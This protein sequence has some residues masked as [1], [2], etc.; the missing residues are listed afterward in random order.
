MINSYYFSPFSLERPTYF[1]FSSAWIEHIPFSFWL[2]E[3]L[4]PNIIVEL[5]THKGHSYFSFCQAVKKLKMD[6]RCYA[7]DHW[8]GDEHSGFYGSEVYKIVQNYNDRHYSSFSNLVRSTFNEASAHFLDKSIDLLHIDGQH[9]YDDVKNDFKKWEP[10]L[11]KKSIVLFHDTNVRERNFGVFKFWNE[12]EKKFPSF[13]FLHGY[14]LGVL[15]YGE[16]LSKEMDLFF[17][18]TSSNR[19]IVNVRDI[20]SRLGR[21]L[22]N[23]GRVKDIDVLDETVKN[24]NREIADKNIEISK[25]IEEIARK[26]VEIESILA[27]KDIEIESIL[28][29]T[30]WK[31]TVPLRILK[32]CMKRIKIPFTA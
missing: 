11:S 16:I 12:I 4:K 28:T 30:S 14:G 13:E 7:V 1:D 27:K 10:K 18:S 26:D 19:D 15:G 2:V 17:K 5:G 20:Y 24:L 21:D 31:M 23:L 9:F 6:T 32:K 22:I 3:T 29:S 25:M 8:K